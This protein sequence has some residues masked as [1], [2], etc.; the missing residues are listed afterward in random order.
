ML[1]EGELSKE[2]ERKMIAWVG[3][4]YL[5]I[6]IFMNYYAISIVCT[7]YLFIRILSGLRK[8]YLNA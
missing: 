2:G 1:I 6:F 5:L 8:L 4:T 3:N 7:L